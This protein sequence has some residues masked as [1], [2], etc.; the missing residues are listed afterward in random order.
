M[1]TIRALSNALLFV[2]RSAVVLILA[3]M[4]IM[5]F[6]Q[7][8]LR[9]VFSTGILWADT[10]LRHMVLWIGFLGASLAAQSER[11]ISIDVLSRFVPERA[12]HLLRSVIYLFAA[13]VCFILAEA[14]LTFLAAERQA[15]T[16]LLTIG[17]TDLPG[18]YFQLIIPVGF[19]LIALRFLLRL[20]EHVIAF[21]SPARSE[22][23]EAEGRGT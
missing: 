22:S 7:V 15:G 6:L 2:E 23:L 4:V 8:V 19:G 17:E 21:L 10:M 18:W 14:S 3:A 13:I 12:K 20:L 16:I 11:H 5:A 9:N 1:R